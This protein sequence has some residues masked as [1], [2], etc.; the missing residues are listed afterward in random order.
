MVQV[1]VL[2]QLNLLKQVQHLTWLDSVF[3]EG[4]CKLDLKWY[5]NMQ[6]WRKEKEE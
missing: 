1:C 2:A 4:E 6:C 5:F 3:F